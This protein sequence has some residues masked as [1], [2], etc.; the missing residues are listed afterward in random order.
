MKDV[1]VFYQ[2]EDLWDISSEIFG[3][4]EVPMTPNYYIMKL[5]GENDVEF[6]NSIPYTPSGKR[7]MTGLLVARN[8]G[9]NYGQLVMY[10]MPKDRIIYGPMQIESQIDQSPEISKEFSLWNSA[11]STYIRGNLFVIPIEDSLVYV[12]PVYLEASN[13]GSLPEVRFNMTITSHR[14]G[15]L[16]IET[17]G[18]FITIA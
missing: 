5:P 8:D 13:T 4:Q 16:A 9:A 7:N 12:E 11:G 6:I 14:L 18:I 10:Q 17:I 3:T 15:A 2:G 1:K